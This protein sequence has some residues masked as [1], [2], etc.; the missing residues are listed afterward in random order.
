MASLGISHIMD[1]RALT[2]ADEVMA[3]TNGEGVDVVLNSLSGEFIPASLGI[4]RPGGRFIEIGKR[5]VWNSERVAAEYPVSPTTSSTWAR[6]VSRT[7]P[8]LARCC[9]R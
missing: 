5:G 6:P 8:R 9:A 3:R 2:F 7:R 1:S 4:L